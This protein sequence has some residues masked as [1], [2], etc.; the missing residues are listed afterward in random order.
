VPG[1]FEHIVKRALHFFPDRK[2]VR[3]DDH[4]SS[5]GGIFRQI[6]AFDDLVI[7]FRIIFAALWQCFAHSYKVKSK[8]AKG[9]SKK[10]ILYFLFFTFTF[11]LA[12]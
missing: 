3:L 6:G 1:R 11:C 9:K 12:F 8:K 7:P 4:A 5:H 10:R 2:A